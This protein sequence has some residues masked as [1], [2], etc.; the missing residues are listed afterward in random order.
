MRICR[1]EPVPSESTHRIIRLREIL[2]CRNGGPGPTLRESNARPYADCACFHSLG[3]S[4]QLALKD[5]D[6]ADSLP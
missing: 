1:R 5:L 2:G 3:E 4:P 6:S